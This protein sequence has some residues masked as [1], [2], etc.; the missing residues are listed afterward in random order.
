MLICSCD[1]IDCI[2]LFTNSLNVFVEFTEAVE[3]FNLLVPL[4]EKRKAYQRIFK[5]IISFAI[6]RYDDSIHETLSGSGYQRDDLFYGAL[7]HVEHEQKDLTVLSYHTSPLKRAAAVSTIA[8]PSFGAPSGKTVK[9][10]MRSR[11]GPLLSDASRRRL[12][13]RDGGT[14]ASN[15]KPRA[16]IP[17]SQ[18]QS[19]TDV[20][21]NEALKKMKQKTRR[22]ELTA[23]SSESAGGKREGK[24]EQAI[25]AVM[26][27]YDKFVKKHGINEGSAWKR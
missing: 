6:W 12:A 15:E 27:D 11:T 3:K 18:R 24:A 19:K 7:G 8:G 13:Q 23:R 25:A 1:E 16:F 10:E 14:G 21:A 9:D 2:Y 22:E 20:M 5:W 4:E 26:K 17:F